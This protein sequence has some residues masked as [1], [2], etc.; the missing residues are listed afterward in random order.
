VL[1][2]NVAQVLQRMPPRLHTLALHPSALS[3]DRVRAYPHLVT[4][5]SAVAA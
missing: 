1:A 3:V 4:E 2:S 5:G